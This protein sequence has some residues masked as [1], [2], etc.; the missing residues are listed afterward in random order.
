MDIHIQ[1]AGIQLGPYNE[2]QVRDYLAEGLLSMTD[3]ARPEGSPDWILVSDLLAKL[4]PPAAAPPPPDPDAVFAPEDPPAEPKRAPEAAA[5]VTHLP[6]RTVE[7]KKVSLPALVEALAGKTLPLG[8]QAP[9]APLIPGKG[10]T[11]SKSFSTTAPLVQSTKQMSHT[12]L[13]KAL[14][15]RTEPM[16]SR[17]AGPSSTLP[18]RP[19]LRKPLA[20]APDTTGPMAAGATEA[21][22]APP[23]TEAKKSGG[24]PSLIKALTAK[25]VPMRSNQAP[26]TPA[27]AP[28]TPAAGTP[29]PSAPPVPGGRSSTSPVTAP[30]PTRAII[31]PTRPAAP[32]APELNVPT[33][34]LPASRKAAELRA[35]AAQKAAAETKPE[36]APKP[37]P[38]AALEPVED[39]PAPPKR[40]NFTPILLAL[41]GLLA[42]AGLYYVWSP[43]HTAATLLDALGTGNPFDLEHET[44]FAAVR[45]GLKAQVQT[46]AASSG[47]QVSPD[48][49]AMLDKSVDL[50]VTPSGIS[51]LVTK[52]VQFS[53]DDLDQAISP[54]V[55]GSIVGTF[56][57]QP[58]RSKGLASLTDFVMTTDVAALHLKFQGLAWKLDHID[59]LPT[60]TAPAGNGSAP[61]LLAPVVQ[62]YL[63]R[64]QAAV[65]QGDWNAA[66]ADFSQAIAI[67]PHS[68]IAY[69]ARGTARQSKGDFDGA[70]AD[71]T[72]ALTI[73]PQMAAA[74]NGRGN[75]RAAK[76]DLD[77]AI[78]DFTQAVKL[79]PTLATAYDSRG[80]AKTAK[81]DLD[82]AIADFTQAIT[83]DPTLAS[84][85]SDR[86]FARQANG[87]LD[88]AIADYGQ[89]ISLK[90]KTAMAYYNRG[91]ALQSEGNLE[92]AVVDFN[93]ALAFDPRNT[94]A[95]YSRANAK[96]A[97]HDADGAIADYTQALALN[98]KL[99]LAYSYRGQAREAK[100]DLDGAVADY[101]KALELDP[102]I[103]AA[104]FRRG[105]IETR[106]GNLDASIADSSQS[107]DLDPK[108]A[109]AYYNRGFA[110]LVRGNL[111]GAISDLKSFCD[112]APRDRFADNARLYLWLIAKIQA[113]KLDPDQELSDALEN[114]W[115]T[116]T[117][118]FTA[119]TAAF[120][121]GRVTE[122]DYLTSAASTDSAADAAQHCQAWYFAGMKR[123][124]MGDKVTALDYFQKCL[125]TGKK[126]FCEYILAQAQLQTLQTPPPPP[127]PAPVPAAS[128]P[129]VT[130]APPVALPV[131]PP[132]T[133]RAP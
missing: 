117:D 64:G 24:L 9:S 23:P 132:P 57:S 131:T 106:K 10:I 43:Y 18:G 60:A 112:A 51:G 26:P 45:D 49:V 133:T 113:S 74:F 55:A 54:D 118:D 75:A 29:P 130:S 3:K 13:A 28:G 92:G 76:T 80:N 70:V 42:L 105:L 32:P 33:E 7:A 73:D 104:Y 41:F 1:L 111:D 65:G 128:L 107:L 121:L 39:E 67:D 22:P 12:A 53:K 21:P 38:D 123:L 88:G 56:I 81:D 127:A 68:S 14:Q 78:A 99:P 125:A 52:S 129:P 85:F 44:D 101:T 79:D 6:S 25:T 72:Q 58:V 66:I 61:A 31:N 96:Y 2:K 89:A 47:A 17:A 110:K 116:S 91:L 114:T 108:N 37:A 102:K 95:L 120:L 90:P 46:L 40:R 50:Y 59:L 11:S 62:T 77:G 115:N 94:N 109:Q 82:G 126:D 48:A 83:L 15:N 8:P 98:P 63:N 4:P 27:Q 103:A 20:G 36:P 69:D 122:A 30:M 5:G 35:K 86:G 19:D 124:L 16:P 87:N 119:K 97:I 93:R 34:K 71:F 84:A 100:G